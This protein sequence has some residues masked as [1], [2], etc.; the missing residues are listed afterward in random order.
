MLDRVAERAIVL[1]NVDKTRE[2]LLGALTETLAVG[3][4]PLARALGQEVAFIQAGRLLQRRTVSFEAAIAGGFEVD[5]I[6]NGS[7]SRPGQRARPRID[8]SVEAGPSLAE[9]VQFPAEIR[10]SLDVARFRP[11]GAGDPLALDWRV[12]SVQDEKGDELLLSCA[13]E[14]GE[15]PAFGQNAEASEQ[16]KADDGCHSHRRLN[17]ITNAM[18][19]NWLFS[20][21]A[22]KVSASNANVRRRRPQGLRELVHSQYRPHCGKGYL[23][24]GG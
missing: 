11:E 17:A 20:R 16:L 19:A 7:L 14:T 10:Q 3:V 24:G 1:E 2:N 22:S 13:R 9:V 6:D 4:N 21:D 18:K 12:A 15:R 5:Q 8:E 23:R